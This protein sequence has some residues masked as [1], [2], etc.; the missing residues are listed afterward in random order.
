M[1][2]YL[3]VAAGA[4]VGGVFRF[5]LSGSVQKLFNAAFPY[6]TL[7][8]N[9]LGSFFLA[10]I[11][12]YFDAQELISSELKV[13]LTLGLCSGFTTFSTFSLE[14]VY[15]LQDAEY[16]YAVLNAAANLFLTVAAVILAYYLSKFLIGG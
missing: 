15:L 8:V 12:F 1:R 13:L 3:L 2:N 5:W 9:I 4:A 10:F 14:T 11:I 6:G 7:A 16:V